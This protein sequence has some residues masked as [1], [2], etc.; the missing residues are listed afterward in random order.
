MFGGFADRFLCEELKMTAIDGSVDDAGTF[1]G[2]EEFPPNFKE[3]IEK[4]RLNCSRFEGDQYIF[5]R[6]CRGWV[7]WSQQDHQ[8]QPDNF[9]DLISHALQ[10]LIFKKELNCH[11]VQFWA[12]TKTSEGRTLL[13]TQFQPFAIGTAEYALD[14]TRK[15][16]EYRMGMCREEYNSFYADAECAEEQLGLPGRVFLNKLP[17]HAPDV[18]H[19]TLKEYPQRDLALHCGIQSSWAVPVFHHFSHTCVG[20]LEIVSPCSMVRDWHDKSFLGEMYD[21]FQE[22]G[23]QCFVG[24]NHYEMEIRD[25]NKARTTAFQELNTVLK[26]VCE[27]HNLPF[28]MTWVPCS[29][30]NGLLQG[31]LL[32]EAVEYCGHNEDEFDEFVKVIKCSH[33]GK[34]GVAGMLL[35]SPN[36]LYCSDITQLSLTE[37][38]LVPYAQL[39]E[40]RG[41]FTLCLQSSYTANDI[42]AVEFFL[43]TR[44]R[45]GDNSW[46]LLS[47]ILGTMEDNFKTF[48]LASGQELGELLSVK[49]IDFQK[50]QKL[51]S[52]QKIQAKGGGVM[53]HLRQLDQASTGA[54][55]SGTNVISEDQNYI[56]S[57]LE[58][59]QNGEVTMQ[60]DSSRQ[61][62]LDPPNNGQNVVIEERN[63][64]T[65][66]SSKERKRKTERKHRGTG[67]RIEV[68]WED[69]L[70]C[71]KNKM[72]RKGAA[73][74]LQVSISTLKRVCRDYGLDRWPPRNQNIKKFPSFRS[75]PVENEGQT[76]QHLNS[77]LP[78]NQAS[79][80]VAHT[81]PAFQGANIVTI[82]ANYENNM[83][84]FRLSLPSRLVALQQEVAK[85]LN[86]EAGTYYIRYEDEENELI[87]IACD[88]DLQDCIDTFKSLGNTSVVVQ[89]EPK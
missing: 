75:S 60:L 86:L 17:E 84:K 58:A 4:E 38:P 11:L 26:T 62:P 15:L 8:T 10:K 61:P 5:E 21:I 41:W 19:Y 1:L 23:L 28:A 89:L 25:E 27:I 87:L 18:K 40:F 68:S 66:N 63:I 76:R 31:P 81:K 83:I 78:S 36:M 77:D 22:F 44:N 42:Y 82:R 30:C 67:V 88:Q 55:Y 56:L 45:C 54:I 46:T 64:I 52:V 13:T 9:A 74:K 6:P 49:V 85:R 16:C 20:V 43:P 14:E 32:S 35:S 2:V 12:P 57:S 3:Y 51:H 53:L 48:K 80:S 71:A 50:G 24:Y 39:M 33:L 59:L 65:V 70:E 29:V 79:D 72:S 34:G 47:L 7:F 73:E 37:Y 69:I